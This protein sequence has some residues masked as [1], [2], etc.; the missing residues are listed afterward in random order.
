MGDDDKVTRK[1][2]AVE[3]QLPL[4]TVLTLTARNG[5]GVRTTMIA[6]VVAAPTR[7]R[8]L[9]TFGGEGGEVTMSKPE[10]DAV[11]QNKVYASRL[12]EWAP[13][14]GRCFMWIRGPRTAEGT[15]SHP[16]PREGIADCAACASAQRRSAL[17][18][19]HGAEACHAPGAAFAGQPP[20]SNA[21]GGLDTRPHGR[22]I[23]VR[24]EDVRPL[25]RQEYAPERAVRVPP[26]LVRGRAIDLDPRR[27]CSL[28]PARRQGAR[29]MSRPDLIRRREMFT[30]RAR[31]PEL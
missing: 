25:A 16:G 2:A 8:Y 18:A 26:T 21:P 22:W 19:H 6:D 9:A 29:C 3:Q 11:E 31:A 13:H 7:G 24:L 5:A 14:C 20:G 23:A 12:Q 4:T 27:R 1:V 10:Q 15:E 17:P 30:I 28:R